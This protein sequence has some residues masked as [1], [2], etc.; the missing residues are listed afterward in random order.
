MIIKNDK[1]MRKF[2]HVWKI[3]Y[4][5]TSKMYMKIEKGGYIFISFLFRDKKYKKTQKIMSSKKRIGE[6]DT[7][8]AK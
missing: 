3:E 2:H 8:W 4:N 1:K 5:D 6:L 7:H